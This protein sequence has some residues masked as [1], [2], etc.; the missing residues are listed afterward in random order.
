MGRGEK[1]GRGRK[2]GEGVGG[3]R[4]EKRQ[5]AVRRLL[6]AVTPAIGGFFKAAWQISTL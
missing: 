6:S 4:E 2:E 1:E 3:G 5:R